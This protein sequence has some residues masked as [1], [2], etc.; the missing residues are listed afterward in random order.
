MRNLDTILAATDR[1]LTCEI[2]SNLS[3]MISCAL[4]ISLVSLNT[5]L[6]K[7]LS[8]PGHGSWRLH[9]MVRLER[10]ADED[11]DQDDKEC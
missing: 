2:G 1:E 3:A 10:L 4:V 8:P 5:L 7:M 9:G 11:C 6:W